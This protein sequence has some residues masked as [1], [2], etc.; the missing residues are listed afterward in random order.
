M[1]T[2]R[3]VAIVVMVALSVVGTAIGSAESL[4]IDKSGVALLG[5]VNTGLGALALVLPKVQGNGDPEPHG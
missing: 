5:L 2:G 4:G 1:S 3:I